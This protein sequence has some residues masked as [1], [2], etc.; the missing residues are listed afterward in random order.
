MQP[1]L[2][3]ILMQE[4]VANPTRRANHLGL[5]Q[6]LHQK[7]FRFTGILIYGIDL[8]I[9]PHHEG[10]SR[11]R[12]GTWSG[13]RWTLWRQ[14]ISHRTRTPAADGEVVWSWRRDPGVKLARS[15]ALTTVARQ[16]AHRG[17]HEGN[18]KTIARGKPGCLGCTCSSTR[19]H[20]CSTFAHGTAGAVGARLSLRPS[21]RERD[22]E[23]QNPGENQPRE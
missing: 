14:V 4:G 23:M 16:A 3:L 21:V 12:H 17:E 8:A 19:V 11:D 9:P 18:R 15:I 20:F 2:R 7:I 10:R 1:L 13:L 22:N 5:C 6:A